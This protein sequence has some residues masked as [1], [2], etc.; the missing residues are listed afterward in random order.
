MANLLLLLLL[1]TISILII[2]MSVS[3]RFIYFDRPTLRFDF[4][5]FNITLLPSS[6]ER[7]KNEKNNNIF[8]STKNRLARA[9]S[10]KKSL[11][12]LLKHSDLK[13]EKI[14]L[15]LAGTVPASFV[16]QEKNISTLIFIIIAYLSFKSGN[17]IT[18]DTHFISYGESDSKTY[19]DVSLTSTFFHILIA[20]FI[21]SRENAKKKRKRV[22]KIVRE[23]NE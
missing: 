13:I 21:F 15:K 6:R 8:K 16:L 14:D 3:V 4:L 1:I 10:L 22:K 5:F 9:V 11:D 17:L 23:Q 2:L 12:Y 7:I 18:E 20:I 19:I